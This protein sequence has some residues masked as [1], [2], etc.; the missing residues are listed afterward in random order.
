M[1]A[2]NYFIW[3]PRLRADGVLVFNVTPGEQSQLSARSKTF[4]KELVRSLKIK[5]SLK[6]FEVLAYRS[7]YHGEPDAEAWEDRLPVNWRVT[8]TLAKPPDQLPRLKHEFVG[9]TAFSVE[10]LDEPPPKEIGGMVIADF[11]TMKEAE[12]AQ[13]KIGAS[14]KIHKLARAQRSPLP[15][16]ELVEP[17]ASLV[18]MQIYLGIFPEPFIKTAAKYVSAV[19]SICRSNGGITNFEERAAEWDEFFDPQ[20]FE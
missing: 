16:F 19:E 4:I 14:V 5:S 20:G 13:S 12:K 18:Q 17:G 7:S 9:T 2:P 1:E 6:S 8:A 15:A 3:H 11:Q 10:S